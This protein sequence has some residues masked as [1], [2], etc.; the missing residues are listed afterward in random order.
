MDIKGVRDTIAAI[1]KGIPDE[2]AECMKKN[3]HEFTEDI[4][5]Q[6]YSGLDGESNSLRPSYSDDPYFFTK[7]SGRFY[8]HPELYVAWKQEITPPEMGEKLGLPPR[9]LDIPNLFIDGTFHRSITAVPIDG[10]VS[11]GSDGF[12]AGPLIEKKYGKSIFKLTDAAVANFN[13]GLLIPWLE[14]YIKDSAK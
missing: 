12:D 6:L 13:E 7:E 2:V 1:C 10:G 9:P 11:V 5:E 3:R 4:R 8:Q 14:Q